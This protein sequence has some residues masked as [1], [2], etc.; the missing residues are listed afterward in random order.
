MSK[1]SF[2]LSLQWECRSDWLNFCKTK[3]AIVLTAKRRMIVFL[4]ICLSLLLQPDATIQERRIKWDGWEKLMESQVTHFFHLFLLL[5]SLLSVFWNL[6]NP[7]QNRR[8][9]FALSPQMCHINSTAAVP[10]NVHRHSLHILI[11]IFFQPLHCCA[12]LQFVCV[13]EREVW[14]LLALRSS[15]KL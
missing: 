8:L 12:C 1:V 9:L 7:S 11:S 3:R 15:I 10:I 6:L 5:P 14:Q 13:F 4:F 2:I